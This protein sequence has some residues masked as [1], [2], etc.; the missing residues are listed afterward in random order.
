MLLLNMLRVSALLLIIVPVEEAMALTRSMQADMAFVTPLSIEVA[1]M[2]SAQGGGTT[3]KVMLAGAVD[4]T[5]SIVTGNYTG[6]EGITATKATCQ[7][8]AAPMVSCQDASLV[9]AMAPGA[10]TNLLL[11]MPA[12]MGANE[13]DITIVYN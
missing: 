10:G 11:G 8:G 13:F 9:S 12:G 4:Q 5:I 1:P 3:G 2:V 6:S 7:Y